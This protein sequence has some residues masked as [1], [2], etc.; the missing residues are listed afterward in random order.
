MNTDFKS[1]LIFT[2]REMLRTVGAVLMAAPLAAL[3]DD[4]T[5]KK[6]LI[7]GSLWSPAGSDGKLS[8]IL[9]GT[10][11]PVNTLVTDESLFKGI[12]QDCFWV[13]EFKA[14]VTPKKSQCGC[15][16]N[17]GCIVGDA[18][19]DSSW[20]NMLKGLPLGVC[21][22]PEFIDSGK[23]E[24]GIKRI[25]IDMKSVLLPVTGGENITPEVTATVAKQ[26]GS[27]SITVVDGGKRV[28]IDLKA[29][30]SAKKLDLL[31]KALSAAGT[32]IDRFKA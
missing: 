23:P 14:A 6:N 31:E 32:K 2:R 29:G 27:T 12:C 9:S 7:K 1:S 20:Q 25:T 4:T 18:V 22:S 13:L 3:A 19:K 28:A 26:I 10:A 16:T 8:L 17:A 24:A 30:W 5:P 11:T 21:L 15:D